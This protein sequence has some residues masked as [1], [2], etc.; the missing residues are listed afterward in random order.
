M[1]KRVIFASA[2]FA[3]VS[4]AC[5]ATAPMPHAELSGASHAVEEANESGAA[6]D[7]RARAYLRTAREELATAQ[8]MA[9]EQRTE[10]ARSMALRAEVD[11]QLA[12][13]LAH[14][15]EVSGAQPRAIGGGER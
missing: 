3:I 9:A 2:V 5:A 4:S 1:S 13:A 12:T 6:S 15:G 10:R 11:A 14:E 8:R 7:V